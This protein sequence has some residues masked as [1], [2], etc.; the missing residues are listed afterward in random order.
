MRFWLCATIL[1]NSFYGSCN[2]A[3]IFI[4]NIQRVLIETLPVNRV[5]IISKDHIFSFEVPSDF[6]NFQNSSK[7]IK[8]AQKLGFSTQK[9][10]SQNAWKQQFAISNESGTKLIQSD[11]YWHMCGLDIYPSQYSKDFCS[12]RLTDDP[13]S[14]KYKQI[15]ENV[16]GNHSWTSSAADFP[17]II[18]PWAKIPHYEYRQCFR[19][20]QS[21]F[22]ALLKI[23]KIS[24]K[25]YLHADITTIIPTMQNYT[26]HFFEYWSTTY[27][28]LDLLRLKRLMNS[29]QLYENLKNFY[30]YGDLLIDTENVKIE[31]GFQRSPEQVV[32][33]AKKI[34]RIL[35]P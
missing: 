18:N 19:Y 16:M 17:L 2:L 21:L 24:K 9:F 6:T 12:E 26:Y 25:R 27:G 29:I 3:T 4:E 7:H 30:I 31:K 22:A 8:I 14:F 1:M 34:F 10:F 23:N 32:E 15:K 28:S 11:W 5:Y 20:S 35:E 33:M 13:Y